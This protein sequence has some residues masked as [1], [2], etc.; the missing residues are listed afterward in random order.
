[1][2]NLFVGSVITIP[3]FAEGSNLVISTLDR[4]NKRYAL[5][6]PVE[7][8]IDTKKQKIKDA[9]LNLL[10][11]IAISYNKSTGEM[12]YVTNKE[13]IKELFDNIKPIH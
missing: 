11:S 13:I 3:T 4:N 9:S 5:L 12:L 10:Q 2:E 1:M 7:G 8:K 6:I